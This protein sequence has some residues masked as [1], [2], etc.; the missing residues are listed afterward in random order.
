M[1]VYVCICGTP[2]PHGSDVLHLRS[3]FWTLELCLSLQH[4]RN[5]CSCDYAGTLGGAGAR[6]SPGSTS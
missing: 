4:G 5:Q 1:C 6:G 3:W 2:I